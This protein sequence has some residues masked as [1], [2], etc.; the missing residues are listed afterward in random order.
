MAVRGVVTC[1]FPSEK[2]LKMQSSVGKGM[3]IVLWDKT[4]VICL[5]FLEQGQ[6]VI[7][8]HC[9][10]NS[11]EAEDSNFQPRDEDSLSLAAQ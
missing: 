7:S 6:T 1:E 10:A 11:D 5:D 4:M 8:G 9:I 2:K 3:W